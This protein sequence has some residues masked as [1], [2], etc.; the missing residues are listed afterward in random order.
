MRQRTYLLLT[1]TIF[2]IVALLHLSRLVFHW[3]VMIGGW[4]VPIWV[5]LPGFLVPAWIAS[6]GIK[7]ARQEST[8]P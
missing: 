4:T 1:A 8:R 3:P 7:N 6:Q 5:S 2:A